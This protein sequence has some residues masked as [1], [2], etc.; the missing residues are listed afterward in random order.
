[1]SALLHFHLLA[2]CSLTGGISVESCFEIIDFFK[3]D[4]IE[5]AKVGIEIKIGPISDLTINK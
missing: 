4:I 2:Y 5:I 3:L 1:M